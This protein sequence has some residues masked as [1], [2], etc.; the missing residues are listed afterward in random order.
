MYRKIHSSEFPGFGIGSGDLRH[1]SDAEFLPTSTLF[2]LITGTIS[3]Q[4]PAQ[5]IEVAPSDFSSLS[6]SFPPFK[7][8]TLPVQTRG[9]CLPGSFLE[10][11]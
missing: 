7:Q 8:H 1:L 6:N 9:V 10:K 4:R 11:W 2:P 5:G 3:S